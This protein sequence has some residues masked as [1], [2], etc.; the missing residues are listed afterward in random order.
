MGISGAT[1]DAWRQLFGVFAVWVAGG[2]FE[3]CTA[4]ET[5]PSPA[6]CDP[7]DQVRGF[8]W[9]VKLGKEAICSHCCVEIYRFIV[10]V[11]V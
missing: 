10:P 9:L 3:C 1:T 6:F 5:S 4:P 2:I 11:H 8:R 7:H